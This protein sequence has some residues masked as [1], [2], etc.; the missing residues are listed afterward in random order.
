MGGIQLI[1]CGDFFQLPPII[2]Q[3]PLFATRTTFPTTQQTSSIAVKD[4]EDKTTKKRYCF[5]SSIWKE[6]FPVCYELHHIYRQ[7]SDIQFQHIL[8]DIRWGKWN[9]RIAN[10]LRECVN[11]P[12]KD[13]FGILPSRIFTHK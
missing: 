8:N 11:R 12:L 3:Q 9:D 6:I 5:Q 4:M 7:Q 2:Q 1:C 10:A 13:N